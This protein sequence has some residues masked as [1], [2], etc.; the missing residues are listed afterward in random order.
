MTMERDGTI[1]KTRDGFEVVFERHLAHAPERVWA[2]ITDPSEIQKWFV[3]TEIDARVGGVIVEHHDHVGVSMPG[4]VTR[5]E[6]P[7]FFAHEWDT[8]DADSAPAIEWELIPEGSGTHLILRNRFA[9]LDGAHNT[10]AGW[11]VCVDILTDVLDGADPSAHAV[12]RGTF[13]DGKFTE[14]RAGRGRWA[15]RGALETEYEA[16]VA[17]AAPR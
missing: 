15:D 5:F 6:P 14:T 8:P 7:R 1:R 16:Y 9:T 4:K 17:K 2:M 11:H 10:M 12:P 13:A 3:R